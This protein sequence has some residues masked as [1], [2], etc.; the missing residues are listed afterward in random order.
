MKIK[1][2]LQKK[3]NFYDQFYIEYCQLNP[4]I[5]LNLKLY[6]NKSLFFDIYSY[7][8]FTKM[9]KLIKKY[10]NRLNNPECKTFTKEIDQIN[11]LSFDYYLKVEYQKL[12][13]TKLKYLPINHQHNIFVDL[14]E[15]IMKDQIIDLTNS[16]NLKIFQSFL[17]SFQIVIHSLIKRLEQGIKKKNYSS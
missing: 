3:N 6:Y 8:Y 5:G 10:Q 12:R 13:E 11:Y 15:I 1:S 7:K 14:I 2:S 16:S 9:K 4:I 17:Q